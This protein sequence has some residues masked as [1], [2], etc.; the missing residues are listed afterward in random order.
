[1]SL[2]TWIAYLSF[3]LRYCP[4]PLMA[5]WFLCHIAFWVVVFLYPSMAMGQFDLWWRLLRTALV[6]AVVMYA[7]VTLAALIVRAQRERR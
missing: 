3:L 5:V 2:S 7:P 4:A 1:M 6:M